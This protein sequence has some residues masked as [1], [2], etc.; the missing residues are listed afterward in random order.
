MIDIKVL[1]KAV[2][3]K[4]SG[5][6]WDEVSLILNV[7]T[8]TLRENLLKNNFDIYSLPKN[9]KMAGK[10]C[11]RITQQQIDL[12][13]EMKSNG[14][15]IDKIAE[16]L[17]V[18]VYRLRVH[19]IH[20][21]NPETERKELYPFN[22]DYFKDI[23]TEDKAYF[24]GL[25]AA[26]GSISSS[27]LKIELQEEDNYIL[28][29]FR[30]IISPS[31]PIHIFDRTAK[32]PNSKVTNCFGISSKYLEPIFKEYHIVNRKSFKNTQ[33]P[34]L[35]KEFMPH[36]IRGYFDGDGS[37]Y[38]SKNNLYIKFIGN[39]LFINELLEYLVNELNITK[40]K[41]HQAKD[42]QAYT[43]YFSIARKDDIKLLYNYMYT[44]SNF[45]LTR[46]KLKFDT[47]YGGLINI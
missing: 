11:K 44:N 46:K 20:L 24:L 14:I 18:K 35:N 10:V 39:T 36:F 7:K 47:Y 25:I 43:N 31:R 41:C 28:E 21:I 40:V 30:D 27:G 26:D 6:T 19:K 29:K 45:Y 2:E 9:K 5:K 1:E 4:I 17:N 15:H 37:V 32:K 42:G 22:L 12:A 3:L 8:R 16:E 23:D 33:L 13:I 38:V 34:K